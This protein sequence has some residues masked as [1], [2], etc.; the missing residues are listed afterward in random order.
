MV[1]FSVMQR[2]GVPS[3]VLFLWYACCL[4]GVILVD[5]G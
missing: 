2:Y 1:I 3:L 5:Y 4:Y